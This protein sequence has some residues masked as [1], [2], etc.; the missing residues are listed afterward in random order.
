MYRRK[1][2]FYDPVAPVFEGIRTSAIAALELR[3]GQVVPDLGCGTGLTQLLRE[4]ESA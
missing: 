4:T 2:P 1:A 3:R